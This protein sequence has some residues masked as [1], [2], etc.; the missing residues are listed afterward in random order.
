MPRATEK[1]S[2]FELY[3]KT[4]AKFRR[5]YGLYVD[6]DTVFITRLVN[7]L[8]GIKVEKSLSIPL[9]EKKMADILLENFPD[10]RPLEEETGA[11][12]RKKRQRLSMGQRITSMLENIPEM[13]AI[14]VK[15]TSVFY[16][17]F[18]S[19]IKHGKTLDIDSIVGENPKAEFLNSP[20][21]ISDWMTIDLEG[22]SYV[23][24]CAAKKNLVQDTW[25]Q[26]DSMSLKPLR[27]EAGTWAALRA[28]WHTAPPSPKGAEIRVLLGSKMTL[29]ALSLG[30]MPL[31]WQLTH[32]DSAN[33][34]Q[35]LF[36]NLQSLLIYGQRQLNLKSVSAI[37]VQGENPP[38]GL[39]HKLAELMG[40]IPVKVIAGKPYDGNLIAY[41]LAL[42]AQDMEAKTMNL[43]KSLQKPIS[44]LTTFP[45][46]ESVITL[47][48]AFLT[49][50]FLYSRTQSLESQVRIRQVLNEQT[51]WAQGQANDDIEITN[52]KM[53]ADIA[54]IQEF[55]N[56]RVPLVKVLEAVAETFPDD[57]AM[58]YIAGDD[59][60]WTK[61]KGSTNMSMR[62]TIKPADT[63]TKPETVLENY[64]ETLKDTAA[65]T[66][67][68]P[69]I[70]LT[71]VNIAKT[72]EQLDAII[73]LSK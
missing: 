21:L 12:S 36:P 66:A 18:A 5:S 7:Q 50:L 49:I 14:G 64:L 10:A 55:Y 67:H 3:G 28:A 32:M 4:T 35:S 22:Q 70:S 73:S 61:G 11:Y 72:G 37:V 62:L 69:K 57:A 48:T 19:S 40:G 45:Y 13:V 41:G 51:V 15:D 52:N 44:L 42:G 43:S 38:A 47:A 65:I 46:L 6:G 1:T 56:K 23:L 34:A 31:S 59:A 17:A 8:Q 27:T 33:M 2:I 24:I 63:K 20:T 54:P 60:L 25:Q 71:M 16:Y 68:F 53:K 9:T 39:Q 58:I 29:A 30:S 26:L